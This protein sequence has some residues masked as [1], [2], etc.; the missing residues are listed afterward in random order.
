ML[1]TTWIQVN[2]SEHKRA[3]LIDSDSCFCLQKK[4]TQTDELFKFS[5]LSAFVNISN[6]FFIIK[7]WPKK[8]RKK[9]I[10]RKSQKSQLV[11]NVASDNN[12]KQEDSLL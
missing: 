3:S 10:K 11:N 12:N 4:I 8:K 7:K 2:I 5:F 9:P 6:T 1:I